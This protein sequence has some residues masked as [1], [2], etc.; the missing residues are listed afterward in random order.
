MKTMLVL[1]AATMLLGAGIGSAYAGNLNGQ[2]MSSP[3]TAFQTQ[4]PSVSIGAPSTPPLF[5]IGGIDVRV[6]AP[7]APPYN[8]EAN[9]DL[10]ARGIWGA[11]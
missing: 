3:A 6:W 9:G 10:A 4:L 8:A 5:S 1:R 11:G 7:V 2:T